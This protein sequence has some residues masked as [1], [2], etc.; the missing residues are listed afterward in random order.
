LA[1]QAKGQQTESQIQLSLNPLALAALMAG[2]GGSLPLGAL[3]L[4]FE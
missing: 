4:R 3:S 1:R 2:P